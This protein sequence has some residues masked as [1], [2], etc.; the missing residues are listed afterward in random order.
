MACANPVSAAKLFVHLAPP[1]ASFSLDFLLPRSTRAAA[2]ATAASTRAFPSNTTTRVQSAYLENPSAQT[3]SGAGG[4]GG[5]WPK[6]P[7]A[8]SLSQR[9]PGRRPPA[10]AIAP[11]TSTRRYT[12]A[13]YNPQ[14]DEDGNVM[15][16]E[17]TPRA[18]KV[19]FRL[20]HSHLSPSICPSAHLSVATDSP[21]PRP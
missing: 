8:R 7:A 1:R 17:I 15:K 16:L 12:Q 4:G 14:K 18:A 11:Y 2:V 5:I 21:P 20:H 19:R 6:S 10:S 9:A 3:V 13:V